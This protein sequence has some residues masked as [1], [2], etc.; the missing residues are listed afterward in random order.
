MTVGLV[1][2]PKTV[3]GPQFSKYLLDEC[4]NVQSLRN[5]FVSWGLQEGLMRQRGGAAW[6]FFWSSSLLLW[7]LSSS[8]SL[9]CSLI[10]WWAARLSSTHSCLPPCREQ[11]PACATLCSKFPSQRTARVS[12]S[13]EDSQRNPKPHSSQLQQMDMFSGTLSE[14]Q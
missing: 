8:P 6:S 2:S 5:A 1:S 13:T 4:V 3:S 14:S 12:E 9:G 10:Y 7:L 11:S